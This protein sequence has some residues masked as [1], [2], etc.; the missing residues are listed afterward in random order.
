MTEKE[1]AAEVAAEENDSSDEQKSYDAEYVKKL[2][3]EA[4][5]YRTSKAALKKEFEEVKTKLE[6]LE[7]EKL[8]ETEKDKKKIAELEKALN[9]INGTIK[10]KDIDNLILKASIGKNFVDA[11]TAALLI[12]KEL[13]DAEEINDAS[14]N[15]AIDSLIKSKPFLVGG[16]STNISDGNFAKTT[17]EPSKDPNR[18]FAEWLSK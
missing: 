15:K 17:K 9:D 12:K 11:E 1:V 4:K 16:T 10:A 13:E 14:V 3:A 2:K 5:E 8:T 18:M 7:A 6:A